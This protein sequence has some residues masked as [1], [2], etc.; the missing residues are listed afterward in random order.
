MWEAVEQLRQH[1]TLAP[2]LFSI[3]QL[4]TNILAEIA[5]RDDGDGAATLMATQAHTHAHTH[6]TPVT[7]GSETRSESKVQQRDAAT[8]PACVTGHA[9]SKLWEAGLR[10]GETREGGR[11]G[12]SE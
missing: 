12:G 8:G 3:P 10:A 4:F 5:A 1:C 9:A 11:E 2:E 7:G 6:T